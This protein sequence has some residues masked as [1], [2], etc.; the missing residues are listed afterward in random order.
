MTT[1]IVSD[2]EVLYYDAI[3]LSETKDREGV[4][5][6]RDAV[7]FLLRSGLTKEQIKAVVISMFD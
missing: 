6:G 2:Q 1:L 4:I 7:T 3:F 5:S